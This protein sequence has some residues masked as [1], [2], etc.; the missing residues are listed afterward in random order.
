MTAK[1]DAVVNLLATVGVTFRHKLI[2]EDEA[3]TLVD[4]SSSTAK[5]QVRTEA[6]PNGVVIVELTN[7]SGL[8][9]SAAGEIDITVPA[10]EDWTDNPPLLAPA[11]WVYA[12]VLGVT[13]PPP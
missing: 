3:G 6:G 8:V 5:L 4:F 13:A 2:V 7:S 9:L 12:L 11:R 10:T 1:A